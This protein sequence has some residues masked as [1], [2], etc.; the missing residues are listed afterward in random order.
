MGIIA[1]P[2]EKIKKDYVPYANTFAH[3]AFFPVDIHYDFEKDV[4]IFKGFSKFFD[5][6]EEG[7]QLPYYE[8]LFK[9]RPDG[10]QDLTI[11]RMELK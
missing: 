3:I 5:V 7:E 1:L 2:L 6:I 8:I 4:M 9:D 10:S 11:N